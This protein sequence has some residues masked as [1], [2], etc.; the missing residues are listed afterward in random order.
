MKFLCIVGVLTMSLLFTGCPTGTTQTEDAWV[1]QF[2]KDLTQTEK[3]FFASN[4]ILNSTDP[5]YIS[6]LVSRLSADKRV[7][8]GLSDQVDNAYDDFAQTWPILAKQ[9][10]RTQMIFTVAAVL[11]ALEAN[12]LMA[13]A[14]PTGFDPEVAGL[15]AQ[16]RVTVEK[17]TVFVEKKGT[18]T[19]EEYPSVPTV[20]LTP[21]T[22]AEVV[23][24]ASKITARTLALI[25]SLPRSSALNK[26]KEI[27]RTL[28]VEAAALAGQPLS[29][30]TSPYMESPSE[31][32]DKLKPKYDQIFA[33]LRKAVKASSGRQKVLEEIA[34]LRHEEKAIVK[35]LFDA[36]ETQFSIA[37]AIIEKK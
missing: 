14:L 18:W 24:L 26:K 21:E 13:K 7:P 31:L 3:R 35:S 1:T 10:K 22:R 20:E 27:I 6:K 34:R 33:L 36:T 28:S 25:S 16:F 30:E 4:Y 19:P 29:S 12:V 5:F 8:Q 2:K 11:P 23:S 37:N 32:F 15:I 9:L 17:G